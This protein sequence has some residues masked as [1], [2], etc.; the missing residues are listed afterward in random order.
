M[1]YSFQLVLVT[2][3]SGTHVYRAIFEPERQGLGFLL[4]DE[5]ARSV[6]V[7]DERGDP[8]G[9]MA[10]GMDVGDVTDPVDDPAEAG[11][12]ATAAAHLLRQWHKSGTVPDEVVRIFS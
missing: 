4:L 7:C 1:P 6:R 11:D 3:A 5:A 9:A 12:F 2:S 8:V 10:L